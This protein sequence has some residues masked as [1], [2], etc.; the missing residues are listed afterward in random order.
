MV[1]DTRTLHEKLSDPNIDFL[2]KLRMAVKDGELDYWWGRCNPPNESPDI[3]KRFLEKLSG[4]FEVR[5]IERDSVSG[6]HCLLGEDQCFKFECEISA[7]GTKKK[8]FVKGY[9]FNKG[10]LKGVT[11]QS[12]RELKRPS[13]VINKA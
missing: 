5:W 7:F 4:L 9:F 10:D 6:P 2:K 13:L 3:F 8:Y 1:K 11:I 12:F